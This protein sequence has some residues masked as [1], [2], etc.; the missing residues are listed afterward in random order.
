MYTSINIYM[1]IC[2]QRRHIGRIGLGHGLVLTCFGSYGTYF[3]STCSP[4]TEQVARSW[5]SWGLPGTLSR[6][7]MRHQGSSEDRRRTSETLPGEYGFCFFVA[8]CSCSCSFLPPALPPPSLP[9]SPSFSS[10]LSR[11]DSLF[12]RCSLR[13]LSARPM[14]AGR[15]LQGDPFCFHIPYQY[16]CWS[17][18]VV[19]VSK[20]KTNV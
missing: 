8:S 10:S 18:V 6:C 14:G 19:R 11:G 13:L 16:V 2:E 7:P 12:A 5:P 17:Y 3:H 1:H 15:L 20:P 4:Y 9:P